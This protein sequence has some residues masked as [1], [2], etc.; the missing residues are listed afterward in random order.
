MSDCC[1]I[2][3]STKRTR[4][5]N[6]NKQIK[7][8]EQMIRVYLSLLLHGFPFENP[9][10]AALSFPF[11]ATLFFQITQ[12]LLRGLGVIS[13]HDFSVKVALKAESRMPAGA[14][15]AD[16][17]KRRLATAPNLD[18]MS[19]LNHPK[20]VQR[21]LLGVRG[22]GSIW[23]QFADDDGSIRSGAE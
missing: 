2:K 20:E 10:V 3:W 4:I 15:Q 12:Q 22:L 21:A 13:S 19:P 14:K 17:G 9:T 23:I 18:Q 16:S 8:S 7:A 1:H 6:V 5:G 11:P